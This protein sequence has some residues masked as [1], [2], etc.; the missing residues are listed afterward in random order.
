[1]L[2]ECMQSFSRTVINKRVISSAK[3]ERFVLNYLYEK[4]GVALPGE[5]SCALNV[6]TAR[7][8]VLLN[9]LEGRGLIKRNI[10]PSD[11]RRVEVELTRSGTDEIIM[12]RER[13]LETLDVLVREFGEDDTAQYIRLTNRIIEISEKN[14]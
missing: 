10:D 4:G 1:M 9:C 6:S 2:V 5:I 11:R 12:Y 14:F 8:A 3:G 7:I 13:V